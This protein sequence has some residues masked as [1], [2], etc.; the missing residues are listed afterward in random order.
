MKPLLFAV[1]LL[2][3]VIGYASWP[4][5]SSASNQ[6]G[7]ADAA[8]ARCPGDT[9]VWL[10]IYSDIYHYAGSQYYANTSNGA[11]VCKEDADKA[12]DRASR[13]GS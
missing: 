3:A 10:N 6:F 5:H 12:G 1:G 11:Y 8:Q 13:D 7:S 4:S 2:A 9:V